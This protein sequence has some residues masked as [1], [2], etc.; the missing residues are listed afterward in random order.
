MAV[1]REVNL[2]KLEYSRIDADYYQEISER[3][4]FG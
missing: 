3:R 4:N 2:V 1:W